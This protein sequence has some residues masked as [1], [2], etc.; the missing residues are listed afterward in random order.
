MAHLR[1]PTGIRPGVGLY[2]L[3]LTGDRIWAM[4]CFENGVLPWLTFRDR[5]RAD[6]Q[7]PTSGCVCA[8]AVRSGYAPKP[9]WR[10]FVLAHPQ[11]T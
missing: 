10:P 4:T 5:S 6:S 1:A 3:T 2:V 7:L 8:V 11:L 9:E